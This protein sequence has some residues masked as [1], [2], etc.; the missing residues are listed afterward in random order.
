[1]TGRWSGQKGKARPVLVGRYFRYRMGKVSGPKASGNMQAGAMK[2][3][4]TRRSCLG[5]PVD[6][7]HDHGPE[8]GRKADTKQEVVRPLPH[9]KT[10]RGG[11]GWET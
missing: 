6:P 11:H 3:R 10:N 4:W 5:I 8:M 9:H 1:M 7:A 2:P